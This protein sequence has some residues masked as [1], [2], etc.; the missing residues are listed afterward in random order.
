LDG[1]MKK[2]LPDGDEDFDDDEE[3]EDVFESL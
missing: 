1:K 2:A 3:V